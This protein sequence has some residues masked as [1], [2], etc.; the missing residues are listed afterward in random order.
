VGNKKL[1]E[2]SD[3]RLKTFCCVAKYMSYTKAAQ[4]MHITQPAVTKH[5][6]ELEAQYKERLIERQ[7][8]KIVLTHAGEVL[9]EHSNEI[10]REYSRLDFVMNMMHGEHSGNLRIGASTTIA[11]YVLPPILAKFASKFPEIH[12]TLTS[13]NSNDIETAMVNHHIDLGLIEGDKRLP[14]MKY[15]HLMDDELVAISSAK[16]KW[17]RIDEMTLDELRKV[18]LVLR[19]NGSGT[20]SVLTTALEKHG[21][22]FTDLNVLMQLGSSESIKLFL[23]N[24]E[25]M[26]IISFRCVTRE[27]VSGAMKITELP[28]LE[29][30]RELCFMQQQGEEEG[31]ATLLMQF[32]LHECRI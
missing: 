10:L 30:K 23:E 9:L 3:F 24:S 5:V 20:L 4:E 13:G 18:P 26:S 22:K 14:S 32:A 25:A 2:M 8:N 28:E 31:P 6:H 1:K 21:I 29:M 15:T 7:G 27:L 19:E 12:M 17:A 11:Q 16:S